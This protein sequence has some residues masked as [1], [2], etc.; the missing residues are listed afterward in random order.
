MA[1]IGTWD[2][3]AGG[4]DL[5]GQWGDIVC[6][7]TASLSANGLQVGY[8]G[9]AVAEGYNGPPITEKTLV[10]W[11]RLGESA[12]ARPA[13]AAISLQV[14]GTL[15]FDAIVLGEKGDNQ[16]MVGSGHYK[17][18]VPPLATSVETSRYKLVQLAITYQNI[19]NNRSRITLYRDGVP[20]QQYESGPLQTFEAGKCQVVFGARH[21]LQ[22]AGK[23]LGYLP[24]AVIAAESHDRPLSAVEIKN[25]QPPRSVARPADGPSFALLIGVSD[26]QFLDASTRAH[27]GTSNLRGAENDLRSMALLVRLMGVP[28]D[29]IRVLAAPRLDANDFGS[30]VLGREQPVNMGM[31]DAKMGYATHRE[32]LAGLAWLR[33]K[34]KDHPNSQGIVYYNGHAITTTSGHPALCPLDTRLRA[35]SSPAP[36]APPDLEPALRA[37]RVAQ[38]LEDLLQDATPSRIVTTVHAC[39]DAKGKAT[40]DLLQAALKDAGVK[41]DSEATRSSLRAFLRVCG[42]A[43]LDATLQA[44]RKDGFTAARV[45]DLLHGDP[46]AAD[47]ELKNLI[48][49]PYA[50]ASAFHALPEDR[51]LTVVLETCLQEAP[52][53]ALRPVYQS[54]DVPFVHPNA[55]VLASCDFKQNA[56]AG[57]FDNR[58]HG[59]FT[60]AM[61]SILSQR[62]VYITRSG[63]CFNLHYDQLQDAVSNLLGALGFEAQR[64]SLW[65]N[66]WSK[67]WPVFGRLDWD[68]E[69]ER[70]GEL[71]PARVKEEIHG[72]SNGHLFEIVT[73]T[74]TPT[75]LGFL[76]ITSSAGSGSWAGGNDYWVL[77]SGAFP[78]ANFR[79]RR[80]AGL[81][82]Q[83]P[84]TLSDLCAHYGLSPTGQ[85]TFVRSS[86][87]FAGAGNRTYA[88]VTDY[89]DLLYC[90]PGGSE[91]LTGY[92]KATSTS[93]PLQW[94]RKPDLSADKLAIVATS[95]SLMMADT[96]YVRFVRK[97][98][99][100]NIDCYG[101][102]LSDS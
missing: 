39:L 91:A 92:F 70:T 71:R 54:G 102:M 51:A 31:V 101:D 35:G 49:F 73:D 36:S 87:V 76:V 21:L 46:Y 1:C 37:A 93:N 25:I 64:P 85:T 82:T 9:W 74:A 61:V 16:W 59:A 65:G 58:W 22:D 83:V 11:V 52:G 72:D 96:E 80:P 29:H 55:T 53:R 17:R 27:L 7:G 2:F 90:P 26:Y 89:F 14:K 97:A 44:V 99:P 47:G 10:G 12:D 43:A 86:K 84:S 4:K 32:I 68:K 63:R 79:L 38:G 95:S 77:S 98:G 40:L 78:T 56:Y 100:T 15:E 19:G 34:L 62:S 18:T 41:L 5:S 50:F 28:A 48:S 94:Y 24:G 3:T 81:P 33:Q 88:N 23:V 20:L 13:G 60:W 45:A 42:D 67:D 69:S 30:I 75:R 66:P 6:H 57:V 8:G